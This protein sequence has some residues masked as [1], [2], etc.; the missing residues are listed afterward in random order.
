MTG[1]QYI[2]ISSRAGHATQMEEETLGK[3]TTYP[4]RGRTGEKWTAETSTE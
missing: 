1:M 3:A 2:T 4:E